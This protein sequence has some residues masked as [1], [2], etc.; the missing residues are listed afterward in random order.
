[1][2]TLVTALA[3]QQN[4]SGSTV[5]LE[6]GSEFAG[7]TRAHLKSHEVQSHANVVHAPLTRH[8]SGGK[9][10]AWYDISAL[11]ERGPIDLLI[12][13]GP[14]ALE[15]PHARFP[16]LPLLWDQLSSN[17]VILMDDGNRQGEK[18]VVERWCT[19]YGLESTY[20]PLEEGAYLLKRTTQ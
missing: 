5:A 14:P 9:E 7:E 1:M 6:N 19:D 20:L 15:D 13:D 17:A 8:E 2:S 16:A 11:K 4:G 12:V 3:L 10:Y 18:Q